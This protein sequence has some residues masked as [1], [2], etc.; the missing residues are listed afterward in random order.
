MKIYT[1]T[2]DDGTTGLF[3]GPRVR[4]DDPRIEAYGTVDELNAILGMVRL[5]GL[6]GEF[7]Q[8]FAQAIIRVQNELF[9]LG[10]EL[11]TPNPE[12]KGTATISDRQIGRLEKE[13][14]AWEA[15]LPPL[16]QFILPGGSECGAGLHFGRTVCRRAE[17]CI[18][19]LS[20]QPGVPLRGDV[21]MYLN[22]LS[23]WLFVAARQA[24]LQ[25]DVVEQPWQKP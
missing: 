17:R 25:S 19:T 6:P 4:K 11:A 13:I 5:S 2:G 8:A 7:G 3:G 21:L 14:D 9:E 20:R 15:T 24:N 1:K 10:A 18:L 22:R 12:Q 23:D 16:T